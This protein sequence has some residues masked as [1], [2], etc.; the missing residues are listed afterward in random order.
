MK[1]LR[2]EENAMNYLNSF[3]LADWLNVAAYGLL[4]V[5]VIGT[6]LWRRRQRKQNAVL[7]KLQ[8][9][10]GPASSYDI[11]RVQLGGV[12]SEGMYSNQMRQTFDAIEDSQIA[13]DRGFEQGRFE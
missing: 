3:T 9:R 11:A 12:F 8:G 2:A 5:F 10:L 7:G 1:K 13:R 4:A 6:L